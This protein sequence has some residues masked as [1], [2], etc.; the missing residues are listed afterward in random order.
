MV[1]YVEESLETVLDLLYPGISLKIH[2]QPVLSGNFS[3]FIEI[4]CDA[5]LRYK[6]KSISAK[7][8]CSYT[9][10]HLWEIMKLSS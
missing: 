9:K 4:I 7:F 6:V 1:F 8:K 5:I 10:E 3:V 2:I